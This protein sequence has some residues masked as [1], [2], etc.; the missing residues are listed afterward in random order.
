MT[1]TSTITLA[2]KRALVTGAASGIG[3][4]LARELASRGAR[5]VLLDCNET[6]LN[7]VCDELGALPLLCDVRDNDSVA[8]AAARVER[9]LGAVDLLFA[10]A[11]VAAVGPTCDVPIDDARWVIDVNLIGT[12]I[13]ARHFV[14]PMVRAGQG[15]IAFTA[16]IAGLVGA[17][18][19]A[20]YT[21]S[22]FAV[23]G[24]AESLRVELHSSGLSVTTICPGYVRTGLH[25]ATRYHG[26][27]LSHFLEQAPKWAGLSPERVA[28]LGVDAALNGDAMLTLGV[29][30][31]AVWLKRFS[32][33]AYTSLAGRA[34]RAT[35][36]SA[37]E[38]LKVEG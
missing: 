1:H 37:R 27:P 30:K 18:G 16:S 25:K 23:V 31:V 17:P 7:R 24:L 19:M 26:T 22:K 13:V 3:L 12:L 35:G 11:G 21:A 2:G 29:E 28:R 15:H 9:E 38:F 5:L 32:L 14:P 20:A 34:S 36:F 6:A 33:S 10:N 8:L 4:A